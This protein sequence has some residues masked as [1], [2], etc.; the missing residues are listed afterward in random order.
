MFEQPASRKEPTGQPTVLVL[1]G[2]GFVWRALC[3]VLSARGDWRIVATTRSPKD[4]D[5]TLRL[6]NVGVERRAPLGEDSMR[7]ALHRAD[8][9]VNLVAI[10]HGTA[11]QFHGAHI[12]LPDLLGRAVRKLGGRRLVHVSAIGVDEPRDSVYIQFEGVG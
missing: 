9:V 1:G 8:A 5:P 4:G 10:L 6:P 7:Q 11:Q 2:T 12:K 3:R